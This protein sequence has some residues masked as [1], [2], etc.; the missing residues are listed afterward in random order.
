M[1]LWVEVMWESDEGEEQRAHMMAIE[2]PQLAM[3]CAEQRTSSPWWPAGP[4]QLG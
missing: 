2:W 3:E 1:K 4:C